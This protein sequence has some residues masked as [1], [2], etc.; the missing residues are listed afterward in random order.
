MFSLKRPSPPDNPPDQAARLERIEA[1]LMT[2]TASE[3]RAINQLAAAVEE[4]AKTAG[5]ILDLLKDNA[6]RLSELGRSLALS[7]Q[8][9]AELQAIV[10]SMEGEIVG[11]LGPLTEKL[12]DINESLQPPN[13]ET[14]PLSAAPP[15]P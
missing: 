14:N 13:T 7:E 9:A 11:V 4:L 6:A 12:A 2:L 1:L 3:Q 10:D 15:A 5:K 8:H